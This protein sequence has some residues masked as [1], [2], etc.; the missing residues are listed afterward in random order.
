MKL[1]KEQIADYH[2]DGYLI[3]P[4][5]FS[6]EEVNS[7]RSEIDRL[8]HIEAKTIF[9]ERDGA[10]RSIFLVH[11]K[12]SPVYSEPFR[13]LTRSPRVLGPANQLLGDDKTYIM[14][15]KINVKP[16]LEGTGWLWHQDH[17]Y[18]VH[19]GYPEDDLLTAMV[20]LG[21]TEEI[22]GSLYI[23]PGS[24]KLGLQ[25]HYFDDS[26][27]AFQLPQRAVQVDRL[28]KV[29]KETA[30]PVPIVGKAGTLVLFHCLAIHGSGVNMSP[31]SRWQAYITYNRCANRPNDV[32]NPRG[33][34]TRSLNWEPVPIE[35]DEAIL[36]ASREVASAK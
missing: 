19:D 23:I 18:W 13:A 20:M 16:G 27:A 25:D 17:G 11:E 2:R 30:K 5:A 29:M 22:Q 24:H 6:R 33:E 14:H 9:R 32:P 12:Y 35:S 26:K 3:I 31:D 10:I 34:F 21:D 1:T 36:G 15:T 7:L 8:H 4:D 28:K